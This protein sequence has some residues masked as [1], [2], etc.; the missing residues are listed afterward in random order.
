ML[1]NKISVVI[2]GKSK[3]GL[4]KTVSAIRKFPEF[5]VAGKAINGKYG[6]SLIYNYVPDLIITELDLPDIDGFE[7]SRS[8]HSR[9]FN[10]KIIFMAENSDSAF[11]SLPFHPFDFWIKPVNKLQIENM[12]ERYKIRLKKEMIARKMEYYTKNLDMN[13]KRVF[14]HKSGV[15]VLKLDEIL[16]CKANLSKSDLILTCGEKI[17]LATSINETI[18]IINDNSFLK[19]SRSYWIN[20][21]YLRKIDKR[22]LKCIL[23]TENKTTEV[24]VSR[25]SL[26]MLESLL[27]FQVY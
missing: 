13:T 24:P 3:A 7:L 20:R 9:Q 18:E 10:P 23:F 22:R 12:L 15:V 1:E 19:V 26:N 14:R 8:L 6:L 21:N 4:S 27:T 11:E 25:S 17:Q 5:S 16:V 2:I